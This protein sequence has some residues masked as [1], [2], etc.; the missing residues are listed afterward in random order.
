[1]EYRKDTSVVLR[2]LKFRRCFDLPIA[3][4]VN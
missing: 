2:F 3:L 1:M 4:G